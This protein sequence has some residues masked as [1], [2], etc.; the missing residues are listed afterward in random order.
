MINKIRNLIVLNNLD[1]YI[2]PKNDEFFT[3]Y[4]KTSKL[5]MVSKFTGSAGFILILKNTNHLFVDG[6]YTL[7]AKLQSGK[8]FK[9]LEISK[10]NPGNAI[11]NSK[12]KIKLGFDPKL[13]YDFLDKNSFEKNYYDLAH[14]GLKVPTWYGIEFKTGWEYAYGEFT[15]PMDYTPKDGLGYVGVGVN[16]GQGLFIDKRRAQLLKAKQYQQMTVNQRNNVINDLYRDAAQGN[17]VDD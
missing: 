7:Q 6:R 4:S 1:G 10:I 15:N 3:E 8:R 17:N 2:I 11:Y 5:E 13:F 12:N 9:V 16:V 14:V